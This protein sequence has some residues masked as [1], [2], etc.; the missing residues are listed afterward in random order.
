M[1]V[2][3]LPLKI[4]C[5][6]GTGEEVGHKR[7]AEQIWTSLEETHLRGT[8]CYF[9]WIVA[10][11]ELLWCALLLADG[12]GFRSLRKGPANLEW[13]HPGCDCHWCESRP[14]LPATRRH[15]AIMFVSLRGSYRWERGDSCRQYAAAHFVSPSRLSW[16]PRSSRLLLVLFIGG[17]RPISMRI[18]FG[19]GAMFDLCYRVVVMSDSLMVQTC[20]RQRASAAD[21]MKLRAILLQQALAVMVQYVLLRWMCRDFR[22]SF[23][24]LV[25]KWWTARMRVQQ[26]RWIGKL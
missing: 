21:S 15:A 24:V 5:R 12:C 16:P 22:V 25:S 23:G 11:L 2:H 20:C 19:Q 17:D 14:L 9:H 7:S 3:S 1:C 26:C 8:S 13:P 6:R 10:R 4:F 18:V